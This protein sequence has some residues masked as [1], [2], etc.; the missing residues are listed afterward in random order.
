MCTRSTDSKLR[1]VRFCS[2]SIRPEYVSVK[3]NP[4]PP[5]ASEFPVKGRATGDLGAR[6]E[7]KCEAAVNKR[8]NALAAEAPCARASK[9][10]TARH[11]P[12]PAPD[13]M[14]TLPELDPTQPAKLVP[15][16][17][18]ANSF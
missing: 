17:A 4:M 10:A 1:M 8:L 6:L 9:D 12:I 11:G 5:A 3:T 18:G 14:F 7:V 15:F 13:C 16:Q 2:R